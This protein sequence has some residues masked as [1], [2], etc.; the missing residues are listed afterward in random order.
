MKL[1]SF[2]KLGHFTIKI[3]AV[4]ADIA[5]A[6][7]EEGSFHSNI[8]TIYIDKSIIEKGGADLA[9]VLL[10]ELMHCSYYKNNFNINSSEE[11]LVNGFSNDLTELFTR[12]KLLT[13][14]SKILKGK[15]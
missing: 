11:D 1:P 15:V 4:D 6:G 10:H 12:T 5:A 7:N 14:L 9:C 3:K 13:I 8:K 2:I